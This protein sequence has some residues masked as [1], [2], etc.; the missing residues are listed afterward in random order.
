MPRMGSTE[1]K[2]TWT[3]RVVDS[4]SDNIALLPL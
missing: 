1:G 2:L 4:S 3:E